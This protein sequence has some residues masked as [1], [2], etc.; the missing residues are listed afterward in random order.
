MKRQFNIYA[1]PLLFVLLLIAGSYLDNLN[2]ESNIK[3]STIENT[4]LP[5]LRM[6]LLSE[7]VSSHFGQVP[8]RLENLKIFNLNNSNRSSDLLNSERKG[9]LSLA[10]DFYLGSSH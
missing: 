4:S 2:E 1:R 10:C 3:D 9:H 7:R 8:L 5:K 6:T